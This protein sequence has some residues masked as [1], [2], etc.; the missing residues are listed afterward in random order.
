MSPGKSTTHLSD[1]PFVLA[2]VA[3]AFTFPLMLLGAR[4]QTPPVITAGPAAVEAEITESEAVV[5][6][7]T[8]VESTS[9]VYFGSTPA[10]GQVY[11]DIE[12]MPGEPE[13]DSL[14][15]SH[16]LQLYQLKK[17][18]TYYYKV[19]SS[20]PSGGSVESNVLT[21]KTKGV[22]FTGTPLDGVTVSAST[23]TEAGELALRAT[24]SGAADSLAFLV[25]GAGSFTKTAQKD[26]DGWFAAAENLKPGNYAVAASATGL[27]GDG[28]PITRTSPPVSF[29]V[30]A[31]K[32]EP[33]PEP[34]PE[35][36]PEPAPEPESKLE[37]QPE[38][39]PKTAEAPEI[40]PEEK[41]SEESPIPVAEKPE[42]PEETNPI[43]K[44][45]QEELESFTAASLQATVTAAAPAG[46]SE[47]PA[48]AADVCLENGILPARCPA[49]LKAKFADK[50]CAEAGITTRE[51]CE[52]FLTDGNDGVF[53]GCEEK[54]DDECA[55]VKNLTTIGYM[56]AEVRKQADAAIAEFIKEKKVVAVGGLLPLAAD[57][58]DQTGWWKSAPGENAETA[59]GVLVVDADGDKLQDDFE[60]LKGTDPNKADTDGDGVND[61]EEL[62]AGTDPL[63][64]GKLA[65]PLSAV[66]K[67]FAFRKPLQQPRGSGKIEPTFTVGL[68]APAA[69]DDRAAEPETAGKYTFRGQC[70]PKSVC[71]VY[72]YSYVPMVLATSADENGQFT[73]TLDRSLVDGEHTVYVAV[74]D[75]QGKITSKSNP[76]AFFIREA[77]AV[78]AAEFDIADIPRA[79]VNVSDSPALTSWLTYLWGALGLVI[80]SGAAAWLIVI[81]KKPAGSK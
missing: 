76:L 32:P 9:Y 79:D 57:A 49:W 71:I 50:T 19:R 35:S 44:T 61:M 74:T 77:R 7:Q 20:A 56:P 12:I 52:K 42:Q 5:A 24:V 2:L 26:A 78:T 46:G 55:A 1:V 64:R 8:D 6:W 75:D 14:K 41:K 39:A 47:R 80:L 60:I 37:P 59:P 36:K 27:D 73:Y 18:T 15:V 62:K 31:P 65:A 11:R 81:R 17:G 69:A 40:K 16:R 25:T 48:T 13:T 3:A 28:N 67:T 43:I 45:A 70:Q 53:P 29:S 21:F 23:A 72:I 22:A 10:L 38:S 30:P 63:G 33:T 54:S 4:A 68:A 58:I 66:E 51:A 34:E